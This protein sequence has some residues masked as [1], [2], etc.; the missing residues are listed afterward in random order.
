LN[1]EAT[2]Y[3]DGEIASLRALILDIFS[4]ASTLYEQLANY[5]AGSQMFFSSKININIGG[6]NP[7]LTE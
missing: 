3:I 6:V 4:S 2:T 1:S 5:S 7:V